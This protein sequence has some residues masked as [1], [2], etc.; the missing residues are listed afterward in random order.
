[1]VAMARLWEPY[2]NGT[3]RFSLVVFRQRCPVVSVG[4]ALVMGCSNLSL[5]PDAPSAALGAVPGRAGWLGSL[6]IL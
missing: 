1:M 3:C 6:D 4:G 5:N 2:R